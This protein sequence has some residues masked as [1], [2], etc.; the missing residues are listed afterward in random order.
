[1]D[2]KTY[3]VDPASG[4][5]II[6]RGHVDGQE[7]EMVLLEDFDRVTA[8]RDALQQLLNARDEEIDRLS[9]VEKRFDWLASDC[10]EADIVAGIGWISQ[11]FDTIEQAID[12]LMENQA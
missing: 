2:V 9:M 5:C 1:M 3:M 4:M 12:S 11:G 7:Y 6:P 8:E 10:K